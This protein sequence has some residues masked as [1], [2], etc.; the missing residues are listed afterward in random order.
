MNANLVPFEL[1]G[2]MVLLPVLVLVIRLWAVVGLEGLLIAILAV[3]VVGMVLGAGTLLGW[4]TA[5]VGDM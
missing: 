5:V 3:R 2:V 4:G 1:E